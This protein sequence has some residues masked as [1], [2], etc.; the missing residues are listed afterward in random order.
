MPKKSTRILILIV[1]AVAVITI[2]VFILRAKNRAFR[3]AMDKL[4]PLPLNPFAVANIILSAAQESYISKLHP[5]VQ[6]DFRAEIKECEDSGWTILCTSGYR[7]S[8]KQAILKAEDSRNASPGYSLHEFGFALDINAS[9]GFTNLKKASP[10]KA[11]EDSGIVAIFK[12]Y[13]LKWGGYIKNYKDN[14]HFYRDH[15]RDSLRALAKSQFV[16]RPL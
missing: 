7:S 6:N 1:I 3:E 8:K 2:G 14:V 5:S 11:W 10:T 13:N 12:K 16:T 9:N 15:D 4:V